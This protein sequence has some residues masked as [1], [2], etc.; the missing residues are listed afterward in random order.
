GGHDDREDRG[1]EDGEEVPG[2]DGQ[3]LRDRGEPQPE[4]QR[5]G[6]TAADERAAAKTYGAH[7]RSRGRGGRCAHE[8][9]APAAGAVTRPLRPP[10]RP[11]PVPSPA[12]ITSCQWTSSP[13]VTPA[14]R[15]VPPVIVPATRAPVPI[16]SPRSW[17]KPLSPCSSVHTA[18]PVPPV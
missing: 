2:L 17:L 11:L 13:P 5:E 3:P 1:R 9:G 14:K 6:R 4:R 12:S 10:A 18:W 16:G 7:R 8:R 15:P